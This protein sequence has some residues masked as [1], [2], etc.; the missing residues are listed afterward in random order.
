MTLTRRAGAR[1]LGSIAR[2][3]RAVSLAATDERIPKP[4]RWVAALGLAPIPGPFDEL[5][6]L[7]VAV[8]L[9]LLYRDPLKDAWARAASGR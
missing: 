1:P 4:L 5:V 6:L 7:I 9:A 8:P 3:V 2:T